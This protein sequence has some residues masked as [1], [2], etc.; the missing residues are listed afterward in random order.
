MGG[1]AGLNVMDVGTGAGLPGIPLKIAFPGIHLTLL[2]ATAKKTKFLEHI[3]TKLGL[4]DVEIIN[5]RAE[6]TARLPQYREKYDAVLSRAVA[7]LNT[8]AELTLP[9]ASIGGMFIAQKKG[10]IAEEIKKAEKAIEVLGG[11]VRET[12]RTAIEGPDDD[13]CL[14]IIEK[15]RETPEKYPRRPGIP[16]K[17]PISE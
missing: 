5:G 7:A 17:R 10:D 14:V 16:A 13:R 3:V 9:F 8:L 2:E 6:E 1:G 4:K 12:K 15:I 11:R